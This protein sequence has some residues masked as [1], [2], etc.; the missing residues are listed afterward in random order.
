[1]GKPLECPRCT[2]K[3][4]WNGSEYVCLSCTWTEFKEKP[5]CSRIIEIPKEIRDRREDKTQ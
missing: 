2:S 5:P 4:I 1:M 3:V